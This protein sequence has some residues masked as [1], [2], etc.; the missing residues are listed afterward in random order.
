MI[1]VA[2]CTALV[3][4]SS[5]AFAAPS[6]PADV[7]ETA[8]PKETQPGRE[9]DRAKPEG[10][11]EEELTTKTWTRPAPRLDLHWHLLSLP[12]YAVD[13]AF[14]PVAV[15]V[16]TV[17]RYRLD[18]RLYDALRNDSGTIVVGPKFKISGGDGV[19]L[20]AGLSLNRLFQR[21][22]YVDFGGL[23]RLN[24][25]RELSAQYQRNVPWLEGRSLEFRL[26]YEVDKN[27]P[28]FGI[29]DDSIDERQVLREDF[30]DTYLSLDRSGRGILALIG[31]TK[32]GFRRSTL[33]A[34]TDASRSGVG[35]DPDV[36]LA[37][38]PGFDE[39]TNLLYLR[40]VVGVDTRD[41]NGR[42][43]TGWLSKFEGSLVQGLNGANLSALSGRLTVSR[44]IPILPDRRVL[45]LHAGLGASLPIYSGDEVPLHEL[46][47]LGRRSYLRGYARTRFR[48]RFGWWA[49]AEYRFPMWEYLDTGIALSPTV[50]V[51]V[52][53]V[54]STTATFIDAPVRYSYGVGLRGARD[55]TRML[56]LHF[57]MSP[58]GSQF[59]LVLGQ[60]F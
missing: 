37:P 29:G 7:P 55:T 32:I 28:Y 11:A 59:D 60:D 41:S 9:T 57:A 38:P 6:A 36:P 47:T 24:G 39:T 21:D 23:Y 56:S 34:G 53:G 50:F 13:L 15:L 45:V 16:R 49:G 3:A 43:S 33:S 48:D 35:E 26:D 4:L 51:D 22:F 42:P 20:G 44:F 30:L 58:E 18:L 19:G 25:D 12:E 2:L 17:E 27:I 54:S 14:T 46:V 1:R 31:D 40:M 8:T 52:G 5:S 10:E